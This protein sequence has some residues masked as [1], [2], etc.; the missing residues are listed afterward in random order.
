MCTLSCGMRA[1]SS[2][3]TRNRAWA[4][5]GSAE[6]YPLDHQ[7]SPQFYFLFPEIRGF[8]Q[9]VFFQHGTMTVLLAWWGLDP[10]C[11]RC[12]WYRP[13]LLAAAQRGGRWAWAQV[14]LLQP[15]L[16]PHLCRTAH[17]WFR[18]APGFIF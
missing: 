2:S 12:S 9:H 17:P 11:G 5:I 13:E 3:L 7:G 1:G 8:S 16:S 6:S 18:R 10:V 14:S 4:C 15:Q